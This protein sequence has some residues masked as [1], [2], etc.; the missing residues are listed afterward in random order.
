M[1]VAKYVK[2]VMVLLVQVKF[3]EWVE[4]EAGLHLLENMKKFR[5]SKNKYEGYT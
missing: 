4:K 2:Y 3:Q 5:K 1:E